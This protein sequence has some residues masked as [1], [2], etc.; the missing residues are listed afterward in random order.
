M[1]RARNRGQRCRAARVRR[2]RLARAADAADLGAGQPRAARGVPRRRAA[3]GRGLRPAFVATDAPAGRRPAAARARRRR[4]RR[5]PRPGRRLLGGHQRGRRVEPVAGDHEISI[6]APADMWVEGARD[7]L[8]RLILNLMENALRHTD[9][10]TAVEAQ[11]E[12][13]DGY[14][15]LAVE[16][17]RP[18]I[19]DELSDKIFERFSVAP[20][21]AGGR[22]ASASRSSARSQSPVTGRWARP[23]ARRTRRPLRGAPAGAPALGPRGSRPVGR[24]RPQ[25]TLTRGPTGPQM[26]LAAT[27]QRTDRPSGDPPGPK[28]PHTGSPSAVSLPVRSPPRAGFR[29]SGAGASGL[30]GRLTEIA[31]G[32]AETPHGQVPTGPDSGRSRPGAGWRLHAGAT[33]FSLQTRRAAS[34]AEGGP[35]LDTC[36]IESNDPHPYLSLC[37]ASEFAPSAVA[38]ANAGAG[39]WGHDGLAQLGCTAVQRTDHE[40]PETSAQQALVLVEDHIGRHGGLPDRTCV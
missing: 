13:R 35:M 37:Q 23:P 9:P 31:R 25:L 21:T 12:R 17:D 1:R 7:E 29:R 20:A 36:P 14:I 24:A 40:F 39:R 38:A 28:R 6:S 34:L 10:G 22:A 19:P 2:R 30:V 32:L 4:P 11:V 16:D 18:G 3:R 27:D 26:A 5:R 33:A 8:H 15:V